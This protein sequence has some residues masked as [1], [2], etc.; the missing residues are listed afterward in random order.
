MTNKYVTTPCILHIPRY[1][2]VGEEAE[3]VVK[4]GA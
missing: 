1:T 2:C 3:Y 4:E